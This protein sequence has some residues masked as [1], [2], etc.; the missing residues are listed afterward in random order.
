MREDWVDRL[1]EVRFD[2][3]VEKKLGLS[4]IREMLIKV[5]NSP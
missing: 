1:E 3:K 2:N 4:L 5:V